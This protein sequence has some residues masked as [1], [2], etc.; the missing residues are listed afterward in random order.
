MI[1]QSATP[2][3]GAYNYAYLDENSKRRIRRAILKAVCIPGFQ[4]PFGSTEMPLPPGWGTGGIQV[5]ASLIGRSD[6]LK[7]IDQGA[8]DST[9][10][11]NI[12]RFFE[13]VAQAR[14][15]TRTRQATIIQTR[16]RI[17]ERDLE[18]GQIL[19]FQVPSPEPL[20]R[21]TIHQNEARKLHAHADYGAMQVLLYEDIARF[22][23]IVTSYDYPVL[24]N[25][26]YLM[27]PSPIPKFDNP[28]LHRNEALMIFGA[29]RERRIYAIPPHTD[30]VCLDFQDF[31]FSL[32]AW[33]EGCSQCGAHDSYLDELVESDGG[34]RRY[35]CSDTDYCMERREQRS[36]A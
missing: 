1:P 8:D 32:Q 18:K 35:V 31:P 7:V 15:T 22:G 34:E 21:I 24:V 16:H 25:G 12:R 28:K 14:I 3:E 19:V 20:R 36:A 5:T 11:I 17:P 27:S 13:K 4:V 23:R 10:A 30:V 26:R 9:N 33:E 6:V 2:P 29:G